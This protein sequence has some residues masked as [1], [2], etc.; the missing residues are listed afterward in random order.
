MLEHKR[1]CAG[2]FGAVT[3]IGAG[4]V[5][6]ADSKLLLHAGVAYLV[7][8]AKSDGPLDLDVGDQPAVEV[9]ATYFVT[10]AIGVNLLAAFVTPEVKSAGASLGS[11]GLVPPMLVGQFHFG[12]AGSAIRPYVGAGLNYNFF[13]DETGSLDSLH[14]KVDNSVGL[15]GQVGAN[16]NLAGGQ[17]LNADVRYLKF[18][19]DVSV[20]ANHALDDK[21]KYQ[22]FLI[23]LGLGFWL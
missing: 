23:N 16:M 8:D 18:D 2:I 14:V 21:L 22:G 6:A 9:D 17:T 11:V 12:S 15:V 7:S 13:H 20:G 3:M 19:S 10:P 5:Q 1:L 4:A